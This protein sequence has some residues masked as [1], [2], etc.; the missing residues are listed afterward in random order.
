MKENYNCAYQKAL[1]KIEI[2]KNNYIGGCC[3]FGPTGPTYT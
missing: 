2:Y 3:C 1:Q